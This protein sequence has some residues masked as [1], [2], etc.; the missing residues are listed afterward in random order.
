M[1]DAPHREDAK[2]NLLG[3][4][5]ASIRNHLGEFADEWMRAKIGLVR[6]LNA[7]IELETDLEKLKE[8]RSELNNLLFS[9]EDVTQMSGRL[10]KLFELLRQLRALKNPNSHP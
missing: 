4:F 9:E 1:S 5:Q 6:K 8:F 2:A 7:H 10:T 3:P